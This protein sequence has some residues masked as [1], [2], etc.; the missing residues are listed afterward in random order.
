MTVEPSTL[1]L[2]ATPIGNLGD[3]SA[4]AIEILR[5]VTAVGCE[6]TRTSKRL[7]EAHGISTPLFSMHQHNEHRRVEGVLERLLRG[8]S[9]AVI[10]DAGTP[11][12]SDPG[13][14]L[15]RAVHQRRVMD[16]SLRVRAIPGADALTTALVSSGLP[17]EQFHFEGFLPHKKG[18]ATRLSQL[19]DRDV[20][21]VVYE[22]PH[23]IERLVKELHEVAGPSRWLCVCRELTKQFE[24]QLRGRVEDV[25]DMLQET[26]IKGEFVVVVAPKGYTEEPRESREPID[27]KDSKEINKTTNP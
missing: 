7:M 17:S 5:S 11:G 12:I 10:T 18:R 1:Y 23:R 22:S 3:I 16:R 19:A 13:F 14:L 8:E 9:I 24:E 26:K 27:T 4:R 21:T 20:T 6:D 2:V 25:Q 15:A